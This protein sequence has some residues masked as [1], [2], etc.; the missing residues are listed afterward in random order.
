MTP[1]EP[2]PRTKEA[3]SA[4]DIVPFASRHVK[5]VGALIVGIQRDEFQIPITLEDQPDLE[6]IPA[7]Y[8]QGAGNFWVAVSQ[9]KVIGT[10][11]LLDIG[12]HQGALRKMFVDSRYRGP[13]HGVSARLLDTLLEWSRARGMREVYLGTTEKFLAA[14]RF[15]ERNGFAQI[16][17]DELP[18]TFPKMALDTRFYRCTL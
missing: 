1:R 18:S 8:Q 15:Y 6:N 14:H 7:F 16:A 5:E 13:E 9:G 17:A 4:P 2:A 3:I 10:V 11:A 12:N